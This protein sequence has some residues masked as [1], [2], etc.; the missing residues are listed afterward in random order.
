[1]EIRNRRREKAGEKKQFQT[2]ET[3]NTNMGSNA[4]GKSSI[5][6]KTILNFRHSCF[7]GAGGVAGPHPRYEIGQHAT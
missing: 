2:P 5:K 4:V 6:E 3:E 7:G 1:M